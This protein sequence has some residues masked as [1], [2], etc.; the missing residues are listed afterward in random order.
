MKIY[1]VG[2]GAIG[3]ALSVFLQQEN[4]DVSIIRGSVDHCPT[5]RE[6]IKVFNQKGEVFIQNISTTTFSQIAE[7]NGIVLITTKTFANSFIAN[8]LKGK[9]GNFS[10]ILLQN[11]LN[12]EKP[13]GDFKELYRCVLFSTSQVLENQEVSFK[14]V[15]PSPVGLING[16]LNTL[17]RILSIINTSHFVFE[18][19]TDILKH[20]WDKVI[21]NCAFNS[22]CPLLEVDN[23]VFKNNNEALKLA[24]TVILECSNL[25]SEYGIKTDA[26]GIEK[27]L[28]Q[29]SD[30]AKGQLISTYED[31]RKNRRTEIDSLNLEI[32]KLADELGKPEIVQTTTLLGKLI[33]LKSEILIN[34]KI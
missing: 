25:A 18:T 7:I 20:V 27:K 5:E 31:I 21:I 2:A 32:S 1:I 26:K 14:T 15:A 29:I 22:I 28:M 6:T 34:Q 12:I 17:G 24:R 3:K 4:K 11:G 10:I 33:K 9:K 8:K 23:G 16:N 19:E 13:F 30:R